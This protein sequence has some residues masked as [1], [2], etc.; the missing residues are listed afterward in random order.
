MKI[1][2]LIEEMQ[3]VKAEHPTL[4]ISDVLK[5]FEIHAIRELVNQM[6]LNK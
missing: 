1:E 2:D 3:K 5:L 6:R 4:E